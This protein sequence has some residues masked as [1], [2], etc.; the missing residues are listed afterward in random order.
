MRYALTLAAV[1]WTSFLGLAPATAAPFGGPS[2]DALL[3]AA[4]GTDQLRQIRDLLEAHAAGVRPLDAQIR[5]L[6]EQI[7]D[8]LTGSEPVDSAEITALAQQIFTLRKERDIADMV[9]MVELHALLRPAELKKLAPDEP[10]ALPNQAL[11]SLPEPDDLFGDP[12]GYGRGVSLAP[13]QWERIHALLDANAES[14]RTLAASSRSVRFEAEKLLTKRGRITAA[15]LLPL[16]Q[17]ASGLQDQIDS[18][19]LAM[20]LRIR[21]LLTP[22]Q[23]AKA[24]LLHQRLVAPRAQQ[25]SLPASQI[26]RTDD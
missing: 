15:Q 20:T 18:E 3:V 6:R 25:A 12:L 2:N 23:R 11:V 13:A 17:Q 10:A 5:T 24:A 19:R 9:Y 14:L 21:N 4:D 26:R 7:T 16:Q 8:L 22:A 1:L